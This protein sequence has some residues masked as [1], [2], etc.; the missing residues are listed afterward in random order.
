MNRR[1]F[2][3]SIFLPALACAGFVTAQSVAPA[4]MPWQDPTYD[5]DRPESHAMARPEPGEGKDSWPLWMRH[6]ENRKHWVAEQDVDLLMVGDSIV[7]GWSRIGKPV[8]DAYYGNDH[9]VNIGSSGDHTYHM[10]WHFQNGGLD[11]MKNHNPKVV[12]LMMG[13]N[14]RGDL[15]KKG[16]DTA[17]GILA[18][19][20]EIYAKLPAS[21]VLLLAIFPRAD[22]LDHADRLR[23]QQ[24][25]AI[26]K[27]YADGITVHWLDIGQAFLNADGTLKRELMPDALHPNPDGYRV[28]AEAMKPT[29]RKLMEGT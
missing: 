4:T 1:A 2:Y 16:A 21:K 10:L 13:T 7:F 26:L 29:L 17:Y 8:W 15:A 12:V 18:L 19:L 28:W 25:N 5:K 9:A 6:H 22:K 27:T 3:H 14:N 23:N 24:V 11:G 20:K